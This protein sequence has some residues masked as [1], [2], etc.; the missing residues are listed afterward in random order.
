MES[1][2]TLNDFLS[3]IR[4][5]RRHMSQ[6]ELARPQLQRFED[7]MRQVV[8]IIQSMTRFE[9]ACRTPLEVSRCR[10]IAAGSGQSMESVIDFFQEFARISTAINRMADM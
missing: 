2:F 9:R 4:D 1:T 6:V 5:V 8:A 10:R 7:D 3:A